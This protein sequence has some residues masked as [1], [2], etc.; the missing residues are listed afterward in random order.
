MRF[1]VA[2]ARKDLSRWR[3]DPAAALLWLGIPFLIGGL[4]TMM[5]SGGAKPQGLLLVTDGDDTFLSGAVSGAFSQGLGDLVVV[6]QVSEAEGMARIDDGDASAFLLIPEGFSDALIDGKAMTLTLRTNPSQRILPAIIE[7]TLEILL[8]AGFYV[9]ALFGD[10]ITDMRDAGSN[11][12][13]VVVSGIAVAINDKFAAAGSYLSPLAFDLQVEEPVEQESAV[14]VAV[15][16]LP[17]IVMMTLLFAANTLAADIWEERELG[18]LR[19]LVA[20]PGGLAAFLAGKVL[21]VAVVMFLLAAVTLVAG[22]LYHGLG[23][24]RLPLALLWGTAGGVTLFAWFMLLQMLARTR[25]AASL[26]T[27]ILLFPLL[28]IGGS[29][30]PFAAMPD[31]LVMLGQLT[32]NGF[33]VDRLGRAITAAADPAIAPRA[34]LVLLAVATG[35]LLLGGWRLRGG[36]AQKA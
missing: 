23:L 33:V 9:Q 8:D 26:L 27:T 21:A 28:M 18:T 32:P 14:P 5:M 7:D 35:G 24:E 30:F 19:R 34:W 22:L 13:S 20:A 2:S 36:F 1:V 29:F 25:R 31:G 4:L 12:E 6:E 11:P 16:F 3:R 15:L 17:G 10:A